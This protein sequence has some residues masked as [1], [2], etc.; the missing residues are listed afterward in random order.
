MLFSSAFSGDDTDDDVSALDGFK[1]S[2][3]IRVWDIDGVRQ[4]VDLK[5]F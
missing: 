4:R 1:L 5:R 2:T 3:L